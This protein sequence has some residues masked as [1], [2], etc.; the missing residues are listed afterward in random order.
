MVRRLL[1]GWFF[2]L[3]MLI[4]IIV[5]FVAVNSHKQIQQ[6]IMTSLE[7]SVQIMRMQL[8]DCETA[9]KNAS[10]IPMIAEAYADYIVDGKQTAFRKAVEDFLRQQYAWHDNCLTA[11]LVMLEFPENKYYAMN[12]SSGATFR[13]ISFFYDTAKEKILEVAK[14]LDTATTLVGIEGRVYMVRNLVDSKFRP[15]A[16]LMLEL[17]Q[18]SLTESYDAIWG[19]ENV[20]IFWNDRLLMAGGEDDDEYLPERVSEALKGQKELYE[21]GGRWESIHAYRKVNIYGGTMVAA[22]TI[23]KRITHTELTT[24][25]YLLVL[26]ILFMIPLV[27]QMMR[28]FHK[29]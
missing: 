22:V 9:S 14:E 16:V 6:T 25:E 24:L 13:D 27:I 29:R 12:K 2:P 18:P 10:Y 3:F 26:L 1:F 28:F 8:E 23:D 19:Y 15:Y 17:N 21:A 5:F 4:F 11:E 20:D 7:K